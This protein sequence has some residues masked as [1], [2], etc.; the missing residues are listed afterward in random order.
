M[1]TTRFSGN[2]NYE[3][4]AVA[5]RSGNT[6]TVVTKV[7]K[8]SG[9]GYAGFDN[10]YLWRTVIDGTTTNDE[11]GP[12][13]FTSYST[14]T[15]GSKSKGSLSAGT[16]TWSVTV[17]G[18]SSLGS[19]TVSGSIVVPPDAPAAPTIGT[20]VRVSDTSTTVNWTRNATVS[21]PYDSQQIQRRVYTG[22]W[23]SWATIVTRTTSYSSS[24]AMSISDGGTVANRAYQYQVRAINSG[25]SATSAASV[26]VFTTPG[27][28]SALVAEKTSSGGVKVTVT[29][30]VPYSSYTTTLQYSTDG[31]TS[32]TGLTTLASGV[33]S[34]TWTSPPGGSAVMFR[35][36]AVNDTT[37]VGNGLTSGWRTSNSVPLSAPPAAPSNL[38]PNG[39]AFD[40]DDDATF[41]W[42][43]NT[44]DTSAQTAYELQYRPVS[45]SWTSTGKISSDTAS[46]TFTGG[47]FTNGVS[48]EW[49]VRTWGVNATAGAWSPTATF[50]ASGSPSATITAPGSVLAGSVVVAT[51][52]YFDPES[53]TQSGYQAEL[54]DGDVVLEALS[55]SGDATTVTF[56]VRLEDDSTYKLRVRA[57]DGAGLWSPWDEL[58][59]TTDFPVPSAPVLALT[60]DE[61][62][63]AVIVDI[64]NPSGGA[65]DVVSND[66]YQSLDGET[67]R[68]AVTG[69][70]PDTSTADPIAPVGVPV[71]YKVVAWSDIPSF[72]ESEVSTITT[73]DTRGYWSA[74][75]G[76]GVV[77]PMEYDLKFD[78]S[79]GLHE[80]TLQWFA[81]RGK[82]V[83]F[84]G[85]STERT[86]SVSYLSMTFDEYETAQRLAILPAPHLVRIPDGTVMYGSIS[87]VQ[88]RKRE[89]GFEYRDVSFTLTE[90]EQ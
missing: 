4:E 6:V 36:R 11:W 12:Y 76:Y 58:I 34:Y 2:S 3:L 9:S 57:R 35:A 47:T 39:S 16:K 41:T 8:L 14:L 10:D 66:I 83:E 85:T 27:T 38:S 80:K 44:V 48:Y 33:T 87:E 45:G 21:A 89:N 40:G 52:S 22:E 86:A 30:T 49:Q 61:E 28:P 71:M 59:F 54:Y 63:G 5:T 37:G 56:S 32:W 73:P 78:P 13:N 29:Q 18:A 79:T 70:A 84:S 50:A 88:V 65:V 77:V 23:S 26:T 46:R 15:L 51:W 42:Q 64:D 60:W 74:G 43:Y 69:A 72:T 1:A 20:P 19:A 62:Q 68:L 7:N 24:A 67:W 53:T 55:G 25:G 81:G 82:P 90:T 75:D 17:Q 31:G